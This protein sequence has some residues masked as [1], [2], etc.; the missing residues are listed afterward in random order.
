MVFNSCSTKKENDRKDLETEFEFRHELGSKKDSQFEKSY[1]KK[2][3]NDSLEV[4]CLDSE[5]LVQKAS[6]LQI[7]AGGN[8]LNNKDTLKLEK[9]LLLLN[10]AIQ[11]DKKNDAAYSNMVEVLCTLDRYRDALS[12]L[13]KRSELKKDFAEGYS[14]QGFIYEKLEMKDS[15]EFFYIKALKT[16]DERLKER[17]DIN[18]EVNRA[19]LLFF[20]EGEKKALSQIYIV[21]Q[22]YPDNSYVNRMRYVF[23]N[24]DKE[25]FINNNLK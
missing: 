23:E 3:K 6:L 20:T 4:K 14:F 5:A 21:M 12:V 24:F 17:D 13:K 1:L 8:P 18:D 19:F 16:Y 11:M 7:E 25:E 15:A 22:K 2:T 9:A 10:K